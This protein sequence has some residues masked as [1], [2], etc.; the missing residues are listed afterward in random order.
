MNLIIISVHHII[1][2]KTRGYANKVV[3]AVNEFSARHHG[4][5]PKTLDEIGVNEQQFRKE[6]GISYYMCE[7]NEPRLVYRATR[8]GFGVYHYDF[9]ATSWKYFGD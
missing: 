1:H 7:D 3:A 6:L 4:H 2:E 5:C 9:K 8:H